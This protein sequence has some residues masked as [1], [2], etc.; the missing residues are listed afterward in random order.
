VVGGFEPG[1][2]FTSVD[3]FSARVTGAETRAL[4]ALDLVV[5][6]EEDLPIRASNYQAQTW[7]GV[8]K[9]RADSGLDGDG[10][11][12]PATY[13]AR[14][15]VAAVLDTGIDGLHADLD[16]GKILAAANC[17][18][19]C[20]AVSGTPTDSNGHGTHIAAT[21]A[22]SGEGRAD[23]LYRGVAPAAALV[24]VQV[25]GADGSGNLSSLIAALDWVRAHRAEYGIE[26]VNASFGTDACANGTDAA[27]QAVNSAV[28]DG[29]VV[30]VSAGNEGPERCRI[31]IPAAAA[32]AITV[33][34][35]SDPSRGGFALAP[36]STR[37]P[38]LDGRIKPDV[39][40]PGVG[41]VSAA[42]GSSNGYV[43]YSG[44]SMAAPFVA[45]VAL[46]MLEAGP[47]QT[48]GQVK[49]RLTA[50]AVDWAAAGS[51]TE[52]G[53][54]RL[55]AYAAVAAA[56]APISAPPAAP[57]HLLRT[58]SLAATGATASFPLSVLAGGF[59]LSVTSISTAW[60]TASGAPDF[61]LA[62]VNASGAVVAQASTPF[63]SLWPSRLRQEDMTVSSLAPGAY[64][65]RVTSA[66]GGGPFVLD[67][68]G[69]FA[70]APASVAPPVVTGNVAVGQTL[71]ATA[72][73]WDAAGTLA[74]AYQWRRCDTTGLTC[75]DLVGATGPDY[76]LTD[77]DLGTRLRVAVT[78]SDSSGSATA[79]SEPT[80]PVAARPDT[81]APVVRALASKGRR[82]SSV[83]LLYRVSEQTR[84][85]SERV[86][87]YRRTRVIRTIRT[88]LAVREA[89][90]TYYVFW[91]AP[92]KPQRLRFCVE[93][94]DAVG[95]KSVRSCATVRVR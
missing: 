71:A 43:A 56:G 63:S 36:F 61:D 22:G 75:L 73:T 90:R 29:L 76:T 88:S 85:T 70:P 62:L 55:D 33:G 50:T 86:R 35:M 15:L 74:F 92:R 93:A 82:G 95:H 77:T 91:R 26:V 6:I 53:L 1:R 84:R 65:L 13:S 3:G 83:K 87:V 46:L 25:L 24:S 14:D 31:G 45:G 4:A 28:A 20:A 57:V 69:G 10:D 19:S 72:G 48:P 9:A 81:V 38:T 44:S 18:A 79:V 78:A 32:S 49:A 42:S 59:P 60:S 2:R 68:S 17:L 66:Q 58:G 41:I 54:G 7:F 21:I 67:L 89:G 94:W 11:G 12:A 52:T 8:A 47:A 30:V 37:G 5:M 80:A 27:S 64:T 39:L 40:A 51:D 34:A 16:G 23:R